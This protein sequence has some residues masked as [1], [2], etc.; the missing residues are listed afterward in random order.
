MPKSCVSSGSVHTVGKYSDYHQ[1]LWYSHVRDDL[2]SSQGPA[3][4][5]RAIRMSRI[6]DHRGGIEQ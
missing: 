3:R 2:V 1:I 5:D 4:R 6:N